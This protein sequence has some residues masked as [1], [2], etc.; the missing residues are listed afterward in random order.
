MKNNQFIFTDMDKYIAVDS[1]SGYPYKTDNYL[2]VKVWNSVEEADS[3]YK[4]FK[5]KE[6]WQLRRLYGLEM[7]LP[8]R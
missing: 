3:Y 5:D 2:S 1:S 6:N 7:G 4:H 8:I